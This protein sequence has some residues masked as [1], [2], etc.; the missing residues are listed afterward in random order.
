MGFISAIFLPLASLIS[1][2]KM[3]DLGKYFPRSIISAMR[4]IKLNLKS[5]AGRLAPGN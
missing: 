3:H 5:G 1:C 2:K 4:L